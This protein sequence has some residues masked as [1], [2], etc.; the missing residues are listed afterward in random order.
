MSINTLVAQWLHI[1]GNNVNKYNSLV[2]QWLHIDGNN[3]N[4]HNSLVAQWLHI[5]GNNDNKYNSLVAQW[6]HID[7]NNDNKYNSS[8]LLSDCTL[9]VPV[10]SLHIVNKKLWN[11]DAD[12]YVLV[13][14]P[15]DQSS[16]IEQ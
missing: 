10:Q 4:K 3:V 15:S 13:L 14:F 8:L 16:S 5:D 7:G 2:A 1:D 12:L 9:H 6:L 11:Y